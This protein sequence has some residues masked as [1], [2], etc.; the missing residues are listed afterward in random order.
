MAASKQ[1]VIKYNYFH[2]GPFL[3]HTL[4]SKE[5]VDKIRNLCSKKSTDYRKNLAGFLAHEYEIDKEKLFPIIAP[6]LDSYAQ[7]Y[8]DYTSTSL[9][10]KIEL[11]SSWVN[12]M[13]KFESNPLHVHD[14]S[15]SFVIFT[16]VPKKL[17]EEFNNSVGTCKPGAINFVYTLH[18]SKMM[19]NQRTFFPEVGD[20]FIFPAD[21]H[22]NVN[23]FQSDGE[24]ISVS[25]NIRTTKYGQKI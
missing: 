9:P 25:G 17:K 5:E 19:M 20:F 18:H 23:H 6:Y 13:T 7:A 12:Y 15:L 24:R 14:E 1:Q 16:Q 4:L 3:Y 10:N 11:M 22:H 21:L 2:W 8:L